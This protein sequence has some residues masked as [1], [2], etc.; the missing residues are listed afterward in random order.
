MKGQWKFNTTKYSNRFI[1]YLVYLGV[2]V[3]L[4]SI[5]FIVFSPILLIFGKNSTTTF[6]YINLAILV[7]S[8]FFSSWTLNILTKLEVL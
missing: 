6:I 1:S 2:Q 4:F 8:Y 3:L 5:G 7:S